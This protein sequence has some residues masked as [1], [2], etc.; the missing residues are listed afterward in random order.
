MSSTPPGPCSHLRGQENKSEISW[1]PVLLLET[2]SV[3]AARVKTQKMSDRSEGAGLLS[4][5]FLLFLLL[6][7]LV[8]EQEWKRCS[9]I[10][11]KK[12]WSPM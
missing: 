10:N 8:V 11:E 3:R 7:N 2:S 6:F 1:P 9:K 4:F 12:I 5:F